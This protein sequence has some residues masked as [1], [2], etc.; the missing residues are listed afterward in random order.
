ME[1]TMPRKKAHP[2]DGTPTEFPHR[3]EAMN[4][5]RQCWLSFLFCTNPKVRKDLMQTMDETQSDICRGPGPLWDTFV[6]S[7]PGYLEFWDKYGMGPADSNRFT[8]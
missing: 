6:A 4:L 7:L 1:A 5:Y 3:N 2:L 8:E